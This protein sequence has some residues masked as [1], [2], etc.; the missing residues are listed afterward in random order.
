[1]REEKRTPV[2]DETA[3][4]LDDYFSGGQPDF[5]PPLHLIRL[6]VPAAR[7]GAPA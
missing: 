3:R 6:G 2:L 5:T 1:M 4:W 7:V